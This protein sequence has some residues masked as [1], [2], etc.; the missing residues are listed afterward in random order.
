[1][2][3]DHRGELILPAKQSTGSAAKD[4]LIASLAMKLRESRQGMMRARFDAAQTFTANENHWSNA[5]HFD[6]HTVASLPVRR[7]LRSRSRYEVIENNPYLKGTVLTL[8]NDFVGTGPK[9]QITDERIPEEKR[10]TIQDDFLLWA[11]SV[12][13]RQKLWRMRMAKIVDGES[14]MVPYTNRNKLR[15]SPVLLDLYVIETDRISSHLAPDPTL[16]VGEVDGVRFDRYEQ[17]VSYYLLKQHPGGHVLSPFYNAAK[18]PGDWIPASKMIHWFRQDRGW[19]RGIP[20][21]T[22]SLPLCS[23][24]RRYTLAMV[25]HA[26]I[27]ADITVLLETQMPAST[28]PW[29]NGNG[30]II[31]DDPFDV[32]PVE[33]G[34]I[35]NLPFGYAAKQMEAVPLGQQYDEFTGA[36]LREITRP[37][38]TP[39][40]IA[41]GSSKDSNMA[42]A[43]VDQ[44]IYKG[45]QNAERVH[46]EEA[47]LCR[48]LQWWWSEYILTGGES[49]YLL[50]TDRQYKEPPKHRWRWD[51]VGIDHTDPAKVA[52]ALQIMHDKRFITDEDVQNWY[53]N[54]DLGTWQQEVLAD[55]KFRAKVKTVEPMPPV[56]PNQP[57]PSAD[58]PNGP[59]PK[60]KRPAKQN[61]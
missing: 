9:L 25:R 7:T 42:S 33:M 60:K 27:L 44:H 35:M 57:D 12:N 26:E 34:S 17:P 37:L 39:F 54:R 52:Q 2:L 23:V 28:T 46:C 53:F 43:V 19:L 4:Q 45:G 38:L 5:D 15:Y 6:P 3:L 56:D 51:K 22:P 18:D 58:G 59:P 50:A 20:E 10:K 8:V 41:S 14:F 55:D 48:I 1:M 16:L 24:L 21:T 11:S 49:N 32:F 61:S 47:V 13:L 31:Q 40:N 30:Q 36:L 29:T